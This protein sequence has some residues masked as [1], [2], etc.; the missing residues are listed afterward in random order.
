MLG[1]P[2]ARAATSGYTWKNVQIAGGGFIPGIE[3]SRAE[4][5]LVYSRTDIG[6]AYRLDT[7]TALPTSHATVLAMKDAND[8]GSDLRVGG[9]NAALQWNRASDDATLLEQSPAGVAQSKPLPTG[10][11]QCLELEVDGARDTAHTWLNGTAV[12]GL[13]ADGTATTDVDRQWYAKAWSPA[14][15]DLRLGWESYGD[16][17]DT[18]WFDDVAIGTSRI[19]C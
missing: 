1:A 5:G 14:L 19:G 10:T 7:A 8:G 9:Q 13:T 2:G 17:A 3:F 4:Q 16:G 6:G 11:W 12:D 15:T 18:L